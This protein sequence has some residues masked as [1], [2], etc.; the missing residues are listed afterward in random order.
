MS[1]ESDFSVPNTKHDNSIVNFL[2]A[3]EQQ[4]PGIVKA[5]G[6]GVI[7]GVGGMVSG[8]TKLHL[9]EGGTGS[10]LGLAF[11]ADIAIVDQA[12]DLAIGDKLGGSRLFK[13]TAVDSLAIG[14]AGGVPNPVKN[15]GVTLALVGTGWVL[16]RVY[17]YF[18]DHKS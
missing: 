13:P 4:P 17:N 8:L 7:G 6:F 9:S 12:L 15:F 16:G 5:V 14:F 18:H 3:L 10:V 2:D 1:I 11:A